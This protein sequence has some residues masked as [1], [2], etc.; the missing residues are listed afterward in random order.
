MSGEI[1]S[2][3]IDRRFRHKDGHWIWTH[4]AV[5]LLRDERE[6]PLNLIAQIESLDERRSA[7][8]KLAA[9]RER[10][11]SRCARLPMPWSRRTWI[12]KFSTSIRPRSVARHP[13][14]AAL[15]RVIDEVIHL[16]NP[17]TQRTASSLTL[18]STMHGTTVRRDQP[19]QLHR[20]DGTISYIIDSISPVLDEAGQV[21]GL[22]MVLHDATGE[23]ERTRDLETRARQDR[24]TG[25]VNRSEF[26]LRLRKCFDRA[27]H[28]G[29]PAALV[30][31]DLDRFK[32]VNDTGG[33]AVGDAMLKKVAE[34]CRRQVRN[35]D[36]VARLGGDEFA[37]ILDNCPIDPTDRRATVAGA[38]SSGARAGR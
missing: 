15:G 25:L 19:C 37:I 8:A 4:V 18:R 13:R 23:V 33:H 6:Q 30:A 26:E 35:S 28:L 21:M 32:A 2:Y 27:R 36:T 31:I 16:V 22:V 9:E 10:L 34:T 5:S 29:G 38:E 3:Q 12:L 7:E 20:S 1:R 24:V 17:E 11:R 14:Q